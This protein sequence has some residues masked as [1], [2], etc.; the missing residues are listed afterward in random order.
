MIFD[1]RCIGKHCIAVVAIGYFILA[2]YISH[3]ENVGHRLDLA[4]Y[5]FPFHF[6]TTIEFS[7]NLIPLISS[8]FHPLRANMS[9]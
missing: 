6:S 4:G 2:E 5:G 1:F 7:S 8:A 3:L 9:S